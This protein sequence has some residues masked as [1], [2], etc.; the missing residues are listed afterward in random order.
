M[1]FSDLDF[2]PVTIDDASLL[3][4]YLRKA[5][6]EESNHNVINLFQWMDYYPLWKV[7]TQDYLLLLGV[8]KSKFFSYMPLCEPQYFDQAIAQTK[9]IFDR[10][11]IPFELSCFTEYEKN[12][13]LSLYP[14]TPH[15]T[16]LRNPDHSPEDPGVY[17]RL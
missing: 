1:T 9:A 15:R 5:N 17:K 10:H 6:Y 7:V 2:V 3:C 8:H 11:G 13:V 12:R 14:D 16:R 4:D